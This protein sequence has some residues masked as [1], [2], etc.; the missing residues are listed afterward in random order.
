MYCTCILFCAWSRSVIVWNIDCSDTS[1]Y[2]YFGSKFWC[3]VTCK[4]IWLRAL[5]QTGEIPFHILLQLIFQ[6]FYHCY[7]YFISTDQI[8]DI[9]KNNFNN[10]LQITPFHSYRQ[11][12]HEISLQLL[13]TRES[14]L[15]E[16]R[17]PWEA[18]ARTRLLV[19]W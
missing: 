6:A 4:G 17:S 11:W 8:N 1:I 15:W 3:I 7:H 14:L 9:Q 13:C 12:D 2:L 16:L 18:L 19:R 5:K 10:F